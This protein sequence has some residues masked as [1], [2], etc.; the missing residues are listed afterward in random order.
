MIGTLG[1]QAPE[2]SSGKLGEFS[3]IY[4]LG[5]MIVSLTGTLQDDACWH[6]PIPRCKFSDFFSS[7]LIKMVQLES[8]NRYQDCQEILQEFEVKTGF[9]PLTSI[10]RLFGSDQEDPVTQCNSGVRFHNGDGVVKNE[11]LAVKYYQLSADQGYAMAQCNLGW[12]YEKGFGVV[13]NEK[14]A[15]KY[16]QLS[17][18]QGNAMAQNNLGWI[19]QNGIGVV[20]NEQLAIKYYQLSSDQGNA[21]AQCNLGLCYEKGIGVMKNEQLA[22]ELCQLAEARAEDDDT[23][24]EAQEVIA[25]LKKL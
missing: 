2:T 17:A 13:K 16:Y 1:Y 25:R 18:D 10:Y 19:F 8:E 22:L 20:K 21:R 3:D 23:R 14:L 5:A 6:E 4:S 12:C 15:V 9:N 24:V 11:K 7:I